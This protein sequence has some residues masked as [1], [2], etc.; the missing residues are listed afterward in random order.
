MSTVRRERSDLSEV[1]Q[2]RLEANRQLNR[3]RKVELGQ[4]MTPAGVAKFMASLFSEK[5]DAV[6]LLD[7]GAGVGSLTAAFIDRWGSNVVNVSLYE[8]DRTLASY[9]EETL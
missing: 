1:D 9:L 8:I 3:K 7:A 5:E 2:T 4:F 6:R